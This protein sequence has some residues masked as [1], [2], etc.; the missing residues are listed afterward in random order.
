LEPVWP[1]YFALLAWG[2]E[3]GESETWIW[4]QYNVY[5]DENAEP[6]V[7]VVNFTGALYTPATILEA[8]FEIVEEWDVAITATL[9][10]YSDVSEFG[11]ARAFMPDS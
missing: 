3:P 9:E 10:G 2:L 11:V 8:F 4:N 5:A 7:Y 6:G 1:R